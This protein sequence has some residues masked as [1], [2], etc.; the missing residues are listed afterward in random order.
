[1]RLSGGLGE[2]RGWG[3]GFLR[4]GLPFHV[5]EHFMKMCS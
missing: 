5:H 4:L 1:M 3:S 2:G